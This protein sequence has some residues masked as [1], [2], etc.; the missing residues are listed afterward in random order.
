MP[1]PLP[2]TL[3]SDLSG[4]IVAVGP[5]VSH[6]RRGDQV[7][8]VTNPRFIGAYAEY[9]VASAAMVSRKPTTLT[10]IEAA[11]VPV[12]AVTAWQG[13]F[14]QA[15]PQSRPNSAH[16][17]CGRKRWIL[18]GSAGPTRG[19]ASHR[20]RSNGG[21]ALRAPAS[22]QTRLSTF[23]HIVLRT[24]FT[25]RTQSSIWSVAKHKSVRFRSSVEAAS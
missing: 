14:D 2:L 12:I 9:A 6:L 19:R 13:L 22:A 17:R 8:G 1:Q 25:M 20:D 11:S 21:C 4:E 3:G 15:G 5:G 16:S 23:R 7:Y 24:R 10:H 18:C